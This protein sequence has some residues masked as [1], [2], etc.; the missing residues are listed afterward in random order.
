M[1][2]KRLP[3]TDIPSALLDGLDGL[4]YTSDDMVATMDYLRA[5]DDVM[6]LNIMLGAAGAILATRLRVHDFGDAQ[7]HSGFRIEDKKQNPL[8]L[9]TEAMAIME[10]QTAEQ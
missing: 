4:D 5:V 9:A 10:N 2:E 6:P 3:S 1:T 7:T 8:W